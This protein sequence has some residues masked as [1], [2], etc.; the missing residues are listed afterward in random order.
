MIRRTRRHKAQERT[1]LSNTVLQLVGE[2]ER[3]KPQGA[4]AGLGDDFDRATLNRGFGCWPLFGFLNFRQL[5]SPP[6]EPKS[7]RGQQHQENAYSG[8][9]HIAIMCA[10]VVVV[11]K[12]PYHS[13][14]C[15]ETLR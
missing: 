8:R 7:G 15:P 9:I 14:I 12:S 4:G 11:D 13:L 1:D 10:A 3:W 6:N 5:R 2:C